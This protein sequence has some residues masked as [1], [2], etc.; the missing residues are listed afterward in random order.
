MAVGDF[1]S[2]ID[3]EYVWVDGGS[4]TEPCLI[5]LE[6]SENIYAV[7]YRHYGSTGVHIS[8]FSVDDTGVITA[9]GNLDIISEGGIA[10]GLQDRAWICHAIGDIY[11]VTCDVNS[12]N[13]GFATVSIS[14]DGT[15]ITFKSIIEFNSSFSIHESC[16]KIADGVVAIPHRGNFDLST[17]PDPP[18][19]WTL[20]AILTYRINSSG[21]IGSLLS[22][23]WIFPTE[24]EDIY[25]PFLTKLNGNEYLITYSDHVD[26][27][28]NAQTR[29][30]SSNGIISGSINTTE[31]A[32]SFSAPSSFV[33]L[34]TNI[35]VTVINDD[36]YTFSAGGGAVAY[37]NTADIGTIIYSRMIQLGD[38]CIVAGEGTT[39]NLKL[40]SVS[41]SDDGNT[42]TVLKTLSTDLG[43]FSS[44]TPSILL[45]HT[46][47]FLIA[48][49][50]ASYFGD[51][52]EISTIGF[53]SGLTAVDVET[54]PATSVYMTSAVLN[55][56]LVEDGGQ[57]CTCY[58][59]W[60]TST[61]YGYI[62]GVQA[63]N[64][65]QE[66]GAEITD[67]T[68]N[69]TYH[70][71]AVAFN[72]AYIDYGIDRTFVWTETSTSEIEDRVT[73]YTIRIG[74]GHA[75]TEIFLGGLTT[76]WNLI[77]YSKKPLPAVPA[78]QQWL[79]PFYEVTETGMRF[80]WLLP[81]G[82]KQ[83]IENI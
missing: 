2:V 46:G 40:I 57:T 62:A 42:I 23:D 38:V 83:Y 51:T 43:L 66:F 49:T 75:S 45:G 73:G 22:I 30:I 76:Y 11:V 48:A 74:P 25:Y 15:V 71:R 12:N 59:Q 77:D 18:D 80:Y 35:V 78:E 67:L 31:I 47:T 14:S 55:G 52:C 79:G 8:T 81:D 36:V 13:G 69:T 28:L 4:V 65:G 82:T 5:R 53:T 34:G 50:N 17:P 21:T 33:K 32:S 60:G 68:P 10:F 37:I 72:A 6:N 24:D 56:H 64:E 27:A 63:I 70:F 26:N 54:D 41:I 1:G 44:C 3:T 58:F 29:T 19:V 16:V 39:D 9:L 61:D 20:G 7:A